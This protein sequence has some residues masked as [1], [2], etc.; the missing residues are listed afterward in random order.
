MSSLQIALTKDSYACVFLLTP[1]DGFTHLYHVI[2]YIL[3]NYE[4]CKSSL[5]FPSPTV[6]SENGDSSKAKLSNFKFTTGEQ[7]R[8]VKTVSQGE[9][10]LLGKE[11][12]SPL[13]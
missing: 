9:G 4:V 7:L 3:H 12:Q 13:W 8:C 10:K 1:N 6:N 2:I 11:K 5:F